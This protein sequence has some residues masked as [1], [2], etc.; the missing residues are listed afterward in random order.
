MAFAANA[1]EYQDDLRTAPEE[2]N[3][4]I[5]A[6]INRLDSTISLHVSST[7]GEPITVWPGQTAGCQ[8]RLDACADGHA[9]DGEHDHQ[10]IEV[11]IRRHDAAEARF[12]LWQADGQSSLAAV[13][14]T[15]HGPQP[16]PATP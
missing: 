6:I 3:T 1:H 5:V 2:T 16:C 13:H 7:S 9:P 4:Q 14:R 12:W 10:Y 11:R 8:L 15:I